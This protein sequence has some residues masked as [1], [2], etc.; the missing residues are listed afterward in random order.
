[1]H[2]VFAEMYN[3]KAIAGILVRLPLTD[4]KKDKSRAGPP[5]Q[6]PYT[7]ALPMEAIDRWRL[8]RDLVRGALKLNRDLQNSKQQS[9]SSVAQLRFLS[10]MHDLDGKSAEWIEQVIVGLARSGF[11]SP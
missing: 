1:M 10:L 7:L 6:M 8:H 5:F 11:S 4:R 3:L 2:K 9:S